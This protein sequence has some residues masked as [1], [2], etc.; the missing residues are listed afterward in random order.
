MIV[1]HPNSPAPTPTQGGHDYGFIMQDQPI[2]KKKLVPGNGGMLSKVIVVGVGLVVLLIVFNVVKGL[3]SPGPNFAGL[4][5]VAQDQQE[6]NHLLTNA[7]AQP[8]LPEA[9]RDFA[10]TSQLGIVNDQREILTYLAH[11]KQKLKPKVLAL[12]VSLKTDTQ[13][14]STASPTVYDSTFRDIMKT[15]L[16]TY[17]KDLKSAYI[18][19]KGKNG[20]IILDKA[21]TNNLLLQ[22][23]LETR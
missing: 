10:L 11:N 9:T 16:E 19:Y 14:G 21:Y 22:K 15:E 2:Q 7:L 17:Q 23:K 12:K 6:I 13:L 3:V 20:R 5:T 18:H 8:A 4:V 1:M